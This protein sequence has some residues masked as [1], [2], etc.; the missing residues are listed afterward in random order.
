MVRSAQVIRS[1]DHRDVTLELR[2][3]STDTPICVGDRVTARG[4]VYIVVGGRAPH[5][6]GSTGRVWVKA[7]I[8]QVF[9][10]E[11]FPSVINAVWSEV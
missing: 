10:S 1:E 2:H 6:F 5:K 9:V 11:F 4:N 8:E 7:S 3:A